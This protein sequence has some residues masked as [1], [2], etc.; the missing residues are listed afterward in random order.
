MRAR[1]L[2]PALWLLLLLLPVPRLRAQGRPLGPWRLTHE[3]RD[4][5]VHGTDTI[6]KELVR[7]CVPDWTYHEV[8]WDVEPDSIC[9]FLNCENPLIAPPQP[10]N[11]QL[12]VHFTATGGTVRLDAESR[13][14]LIAP[15]ASTVTLWAYRG[16]SLLFQHTFKAIP[17]PLP[18]LEC[19]C[20]LRPVFTTGGRELYTCS[21]KAVPTQEFAQT[22]NDDARYRVSKSQVTLLR[23]GNPI[24]SPIIINWQS[25]DISEL[26]KLAKAGDQ[27]KIDVNLIERQNFCGDIETVPL[28][29]H[30]LIAV[31]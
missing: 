3:L 22:L 13:K 14:L 1:F 27:L 19:Y 26:R 31:P 17:P 11:G 21:I 12:P 25:V 2:L 23:N 9:L 28:Q 30:Y 29:K 7:G 8:K 15:F 4:G 10:R 18:I 16:P 5:W 20:S 6:T 24:H